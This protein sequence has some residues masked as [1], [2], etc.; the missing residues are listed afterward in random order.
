MNKLLLAFAALAIAPAAQA[1]T[2]LVVN[3][4]FESFTGGTYND[5]TGTVSG[6]FIPKGTDPNGNS[7]SIN[8]GG[9][10]PVQLNG[11]YEYSTGANQG[12]PFNFLVAPGTIFSSGF[13]DNWDQG[14]RTIHQ[15]S[16]PSS[17]ATSPNGGHFLLMDAGYNP[18]AINQNISGLVDGTSYT[19][20]FDWAASQ[21]SQASGD[22]TQSIKTTIGNSVL[23]TATYSL[24]SGQ[25]SGWMQA[26]ET[27]T[28]EG[29]NNVLSFLAQGTPGGLPPSVL[30]DGVSLTAN[31][32]TSNGNPNPI[33]EPATW[34]LLLAGA[35]GLFAIRR[36]RAAKAG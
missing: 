30:I 14:Y 6:Q 27:F 23:N 24:G 16:A 19:L 11:W 15:G 5:N 31:G 2:N 1:S 26:T 17:A 29:S 4:G 28:Y 33:P 3:G 20:T 10:R 9:Y 8:W 34:A 22:T 35:G 12:S 36:R 18:T 7:F 13:S 32:S 25:F 21:W